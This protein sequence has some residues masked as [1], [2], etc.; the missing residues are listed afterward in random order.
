MTVKAKEQIAPKLYARPRSEEARVSIPSGLSFLLLSHPKLPAL[1]KLLSHITSFRLP[2][3][4]HSRSPTSLLSFHPFVLLT[5]TL[6]S[7]PGSLYR[8]EGSELTHLPVGASQISETGGQ[9]G[10]REDGLPLGDEGTPSF[11][12]GSH[13]PTRHPIPAPRARRTKLSPH[14]GCG[15]CLLCGE[16]L[17][18]AG[19]RDILWESGRG[20][21][22]AERERDREGEE[23]RERESER[24]P[25]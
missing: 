22:R 19:S 14:R 2:L 9:E 17:P 24:K 13:P 10:M 12:R 20:E 5:S 1:P 18:A 11:A 15:L 23:G 7:P 21:R 6:Q 25:Q 16:P 8:S 3:L 4:P